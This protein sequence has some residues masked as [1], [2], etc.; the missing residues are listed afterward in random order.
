MMQKEVGE[1]LIAPVGSKNYGKLTISTQ[2]FADVE[3]I[4]LVPANSFI[5]APKVT[6]IVVKLKFKDSNFDKELLDFIKKCFAMRRKT[7]F[8]NLRNFLDA[9]FSKEIIN[10]LDVKDSVRP[11]E[12]T[13]EQFLTLYKLTKENR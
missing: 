13:K 11:Q 9:D 10:K 3:K 7:L 5:P 1:R 6:S 4:T 12:L 8:N 2:L